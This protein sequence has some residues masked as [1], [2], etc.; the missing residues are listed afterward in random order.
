MN[1]VDD[2]ANIAQLHFEREETIVS[3]RLP[4]RVELI[5]QYGVPIKSSTRT[6]AI[7]ILIQIKSITSLR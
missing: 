2:A 3:A 6:G 5:S 7:C 1:I 4:M